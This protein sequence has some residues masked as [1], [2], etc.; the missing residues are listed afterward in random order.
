[1]VSTVSW[2]PSGMA[3]RALIARLM[4]A[5]S[6]WLES[7]TASGASAS[8]AILERDILADRAAQQLLQTRRAL[9]RVERLGIERLPSREG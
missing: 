4:I 8:G 2:P 6:S 1:M 5:F 7:A 3:S 9:L